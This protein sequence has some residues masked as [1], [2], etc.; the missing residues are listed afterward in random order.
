MGRELIA[1]ATQ[2]DAEEFLRDHKGKRI[3]KFEDITVKVIRSL[4]E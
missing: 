3:L 2:K 1:L 4:D